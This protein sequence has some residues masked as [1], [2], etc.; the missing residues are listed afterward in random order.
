MRT[1]KTR[2]DEKIDVLAQAWTKILSQQGYL[3]LPVPNDIDNIVQWM[4]ELKISAIILSGG[5][6]LTNIGKYVGD[7]DLVRD[8]NE[9]RILDFAMGNRLPILGVCRGF[10]L[11]IRHTS[12]LSPV[13]VKEH[14]GK[15]HHLRFTDAGKAFFKVSKCSVNSYHNF[16][17]QKS[18]I[19]E[20][21]EILSMSLDGVVEAVIHSV[22]PILAVQWHPE[23]IDQGRNV[24]DKFV[25]KWLKDNLK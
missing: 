19:S 20:I 6:S 2:Y 9:E 21:W 24:C 1:D 14:A 13:E 25:W 8:A 15:S 5:N 10:Q 16:G 7:A 23:R 18:Q 11:L 3:P 17:Y 22:H 12:K 4:K